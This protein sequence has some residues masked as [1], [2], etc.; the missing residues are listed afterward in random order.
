LF[1]GEKRGL[2]P[3]KPCT[4]AKKKTEKSGENRLMCR[5]RK[6]RKCQA[7]MTGIKKKKKIR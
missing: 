1:L 3:A 5:N 7:D 2:G 6:R 4:C